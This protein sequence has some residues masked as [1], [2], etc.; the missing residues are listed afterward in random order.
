MAVTVCP[1]QISQDVTHMPS[2][3]ALP[4]A[5]LKPDRA[6]KRHFIDR[7]RPIPPRVR[8]ALYSLY[9]W[10]LHRNLWLSPR[11]RLTAWVS[12]PFKIVELGSLQ[13]QSSGYCLLRGGSRRVVLPAMKC[14]PLDSSLYSRRLEKHSVE[15]Q[16]AYW[17]L[18]SKWRSGVS[19]H[20]ICPD[21]IEVYPI[22]C[23]QKRKLCPMTGIN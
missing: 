5:T 1:K 6:W 8:T 11:S 18:H 2:R 10:A 3:R 14:L 22:L 19:E 21:G 12:K 17:R 13:L 4:E 20:L 16:V 9:S 23:K 15:L 7:T